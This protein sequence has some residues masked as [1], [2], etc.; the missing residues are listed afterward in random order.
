MLIRAPP[1]SVL[2]SAG[3]IIYVGLCMLHS[4]FINHLI[5][6]VA[7]WMLQAD[8]LSALFLISLFEDLPSSDVWILRIP[9]YWWKYSSMSFF[10]QFTYLTLNNHLVMG[11]C[12]EGN[13]LHPPIIFLFS[14]NEKVLLGLM[15]VLLEL[16][17]NPQR[18]YCLELLLLHL[19]STLLRWRRGNLGG[20]FSY[21]SLMFW[22]SWDHLWG[23]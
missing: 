4:H 23:D 3:T 17:Y 16:L 18:K 19:S 12:W 13:T 21:V 2:A 6:S 9:C 8:N 11:Q 14:W 5:C 20:G 22:P 7:S 15:A 1:R 10:K